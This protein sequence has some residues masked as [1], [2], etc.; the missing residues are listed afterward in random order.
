MTEKTVGRK[1]AQT[2]KQKYGEDYYRNLGHKGGSVPRP[3]RGF[4]SK[5]VGKDGLTGPQR[6]KIAGTKGGKNG[7]RAPSKKVS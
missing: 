4:A 3:N 7:S 2:L 1:V 5:F 6:A